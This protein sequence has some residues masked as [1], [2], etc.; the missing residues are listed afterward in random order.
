MIT[1]DDIHKLKDKEKNVALAQYHKDLREKR[2]QDKED[3][4]KMSKKDWAERNRKS[5]K[6]KIL[7]LMYGR[8]CP[9]C[10][11][12]LSIIQIGKET[13]SGCGFELIENNQYCKQHR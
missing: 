10:D 13:C 5:F 7:N 2:I 11:G 1:I 12:R 9:K 4:I 8:P 6:N 3:T